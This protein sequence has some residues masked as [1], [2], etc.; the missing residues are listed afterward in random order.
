MKKYI[1]LIGMWTISILTLS[2]QTR[3][4]GGYPVDISQRPYQAA[5]LI[6]GLF[7]GG[8]VIINSEWILTAAHVVTNGNTPYQPSQISV[9][10]GVTDLT[11]FYAPRASVSQ[12]IVHPKYN[13]STYLNDIALVKLSSPLTWSDNRQPIII[14]DMDNYA[15]STPAVVSGWGQRSTTS[16]SSS[17][18]QLYAGNIH[19]T[20]ANRDSE[21]RYSELQSHIESVAPFY[22]DSGGPVTINESY[23]GDLLVGLVS[24]GPKDDPTKGNVYYTNVGYYQSWIVSNTGNANNATLTIP[25]LITRQDACV[26]QNV[27]ANATVSWSINNPA[28][29]SITSAGFI[30]V[31]GQG[32]L[33]V[34]ALITLPSG[35]K[36]TLHGNTT[37]GIPLMYITVYG[38]EEYE[39]FPERYF[40]TN[41]NYIFVP[42]QTTNFFGNMENL[43]FDFH[44]WLKDASGSVLASRTIKDV[45]MR[46]ALFEVQFPTE[47]TYTLELEVV[48]KDGTSALYTRTIH[49]EGSPYRILSANHQIEIKPQSENSISRLSSNKASS[50]LV[51]LYNN[52]R[53]LRSVSFQPEEGATLDISP[54]PNGFYYLVITENG[55]VKQRQTIAV[56]H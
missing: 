25:R 42:Q 43:N 38:E 14:T 28:I 45:W 30:T 53:L 27:P 36:F 49:A 9:S 11:S 17:L 21:W 39:P 7:N 35:I 15:T 52:N 4:I 48:A 2:A 54:L 6:N 50:S 56:K 24:H 34:T 46:M 32:W 26:L 31:K 23:T 16:G 8:G 41:T 13:P 18:Q 51:Q 19:I 3:I 22:G 47:S 55:K 1:W 40:G 33:K 10:T 12:I 5:V 37:V 44:W 20:S 29:A